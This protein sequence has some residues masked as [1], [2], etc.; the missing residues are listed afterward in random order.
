[1][2]DERPALLSRLREAALARGSGPRDDRDNLF[3]VLMDA[4]RGC[5]LGEITAKRFGC[6]AVVD[7]DGRL[8]GIITDGDVRRAAQRGA[9]T[10][11]A[12]ATALMSTAPKTVGRSQPPLTS[13][14]S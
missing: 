2:A 3:A 1:M 11:P 9:G 12:T 14:C 8:V 10:V 13:R 5:T 4:V 7:G 6:T